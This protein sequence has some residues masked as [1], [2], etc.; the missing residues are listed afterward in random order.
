MLRG[1]LRLVVLLLLIFSESQTFAQISNQIS[2]TITDEQGAPL[3]GVT[4]F[5]HEVSKSSQTNE[6]G[7]FNISGIRQGN[8]HLHLHLIGFKAAEI[9]LPVSETH[10]PLKIKL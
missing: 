3:F 8:Y 7:E 9:D 2:G 4:V 10:Q 6:R 1:S 5:I